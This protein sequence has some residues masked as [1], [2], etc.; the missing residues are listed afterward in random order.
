MDRDRTCKSKF[1]G[2]HARA[3]VV[4]YRTGVLQSEIELRYRPHRA[5]YECMHACARSQPNA[6]FSHCP[7]SCSQAF[8]DEIA[9]PLP[10]TQMS[11]IRLTSGQFLVVDAVAM[12]DPQRYRC[13]YVH[14]NRHVCRPKF[15]VLTESGRP[16]SLIRVLRRSTASTSISHAMHGT[17]QSST[18]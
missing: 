17:G 15:D 12:T 10:G 4:K 7:T 9:C 14:V 8:R 3:R 18:S 2:A 5:G 6:A 1:F 16:D 11:L 13:M